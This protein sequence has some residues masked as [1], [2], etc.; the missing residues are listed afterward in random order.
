MNN[1][2]NS[3]IWIGVL[4]P[5]KFLI[6]LSL[7]NLECT[8]LFLNPATWNRLGASSFGATPSSHLASQKG[9][10]LSSPIEIRVEQKNN[11]LSIG[12]AIF[13]RCFQGLSWWSQPY[14]NHL[15][16]KALLNFSRSLIPRPPNLLGIKHVC[17]LTRQWP[18]LTLSGSCPFHKKLLLNLSILEVPY[19]DIL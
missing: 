7:R 17:Q 12:S 14:H 2:V 15:S 18:P 19:F 16:L 4:M 5:C 3:S 1:R 8:V 13:R 9:V 11:C 10:F 6:Q